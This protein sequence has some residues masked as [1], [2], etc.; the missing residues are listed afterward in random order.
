M[1]DELKTLQLNQRQSREREEQE[2]A[3]LRKRIED[4]SSG[5]AECGSEIESIVRQ[6]QERKQLLDNKRISQTELENQMD[7]E[8]KA[9]VR[10]REEWEQVSLQIQKHSKAIEE[11]NSQKERAAQSQA[12]LERKAL[13]I[14]KQLSATKE[15]LSTM[16]LTMKQLEDQA[17][18]LQ[19]Q[20]SALE[21]QVDRCKE[22]RSLQTAILSNPT[23]QRLLLSVQ[24][25]KECAYP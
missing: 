16:A 14:E 7:Q 19:Q 18:A 10:M 11:L 8:R 2:K 9:Q 15:S 1:I 12:E 21:K 13:E 20:Y 4:E 6:L 22:E 23:L 17:Q 3:V 25:R 5:L 24:N